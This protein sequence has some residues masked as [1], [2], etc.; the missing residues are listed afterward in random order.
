ME[1]NRALKQ[2]RNYIRT[3]YLQPAVQHQHLSGAGAT[4]KL[5]ERLSGY[6]QKK[7]AITFSSATTA[8]QCIC[9]A[10]DIKESEIITS[11]INW[12]G[13][14]A[15]FLLHGNKLRFSA[16]ERTT[17][18][19]DVKDLASAIT[20]K[21]SAVLSVDYCGTPVN[22]EEIKNFCNEYGLK[23][24]SDSAQSFGAKRHG[25][26]AGWHA[27]AIVISFSPGK[28]LFGG[29]GGAVITDD[30]ELYEKLIWNSQHPSKQKT[31]FGISHYNEYAPLNGRLNPLSAIVLNETFE[32]TI[33]EL[34][35]YQGICFKLLKELQ[36][37]K[38]VESSPF[39][40]SPEASTFF[41]FSLK[42]K[43][44]INLQY[45]NDFLSSQKQSFMAIDSTHK[46][47]PFDPAF[48]SQYKGWYSCTGNVL[49]QKAESRCSNWISLIHSY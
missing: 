11:P 15:P 29:E 26:P 21:S 3:C 23:Y 36:A 42:L 16:V 17:L 1:P 25:K 19:L 47:I 4:H 24:I 39:I 31:I 13:S 7:Y 49:K 46:M 37:E 28:S 44:S 32:A 48:K 20:S 27:D 2:I 9:L 6:Y 41:N 22:S 14:I 38:M 34:R 35:K 45:V 8:L 30:Q 12:G 18:N 33:P 43:P 10:M 5:E 40:T